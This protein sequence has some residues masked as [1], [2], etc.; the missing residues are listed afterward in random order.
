MQRAAP[1]PLFLFLLYS[2]FGT[3]NLNKI[4]LENILSLNYEINFIGRRKQWVR[5]L[6]MET[7]QPSSLGQVALLKVGMVQAIALVR[8]QPLV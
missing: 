8:M 5:L 7:Q 2:L 1:G 3:G 4:Y 6:L